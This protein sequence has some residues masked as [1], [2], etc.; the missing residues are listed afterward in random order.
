MVTD[1]QGNN[2][3]KIE[4]FFFFSLISLAAFGLIFK[5]IT[6]PLSQLSSA[7]VIAAVIA[8]FYGIFRY[9]LGERHGKIP[10]KRGQQSVLTLIRPA[11]QKHMNKG[12][13]KESGTKLKRKEYPF[14]VIEGKKGK[15][16]SSLHNKVHH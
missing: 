13:L 14:K 3:A 5:L 7:L 10:K 15:K 2:R 12:E 8:I 16:N 11:A 9:M 6:D 1:M 4:Q